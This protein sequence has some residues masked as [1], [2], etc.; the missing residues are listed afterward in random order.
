[1]LKRE[2]QN[3]SCTVPPPFPST[4]LLVP[5]NLRTQEGTRINHPI[6]A[7]TAITTF[8]TCCRIL[9]EAIKKTEKYHFREDQKCSSFVRL[10]AAASNKLFGTS[11]SV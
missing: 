6:T 10:S 8:I 2:K 4:L 9:E 1:M 11:L 7:I 3:S 5:S